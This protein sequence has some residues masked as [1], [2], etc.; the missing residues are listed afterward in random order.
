MKALVLLSYYKPEIAASIYLFE[1]L[2]DDMKKENI[3]VDLIIPKPSRGIIAGIK[4]EYPKIEKDGSL[5]IRRFAMFNEGTRTSLRAIRYILCCLNYIWYGII[6]KNINVVFAE[7][8][9]PI[10]GAA[11]VIIKKIKK[12]PFIYNLQDI[13][14][15]SLVTTGLSHKNSLAWK[16]GRII[17]KFT[18]NNAD[19]IIVISEDFKKNIILKGVPESKIEVVYNWVDENAVKPIERD[20]NILFDK[21]CLDRN[22]FY[23]TYCGNL[24]LTQ[25]FDMLISIAYELKDIKDLQFI[26][27]GEGV[28]KDKIISHIKE[29]GILNIKLLPFQAYS[30]IS[31]VFSL[32]D[33][34]LIISKPGIGANCVPSK[35]WSIMSAERPVLANFDE[36][37]LKSIIEDNK[38]GIFTVAG[39][40]NNFVKAI[41]YLYNN[42]ENCKKLGKNGR[43]FI[44]E[45]LTRKLG[46][47]KYIDII[48]NTNKQN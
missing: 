46:T 19:K 6:S 23:L 13:F 4:K 15:D 20:K 29:R 40:K 11:A 30:E 48:K 34:G 45:K 32:G 16:I 22:N 42:R 8:T 3:D 21:Y 24:G 44:L 10:L 18:Y 41:H 38:C 2:I 39:D 26:L 14:P 47:K 33:V 35:T 17:E 31:Q 9:P 1:N 37:E 28:Y 7:S 12:V 27:F 36:N 25:N 43:E 5:C